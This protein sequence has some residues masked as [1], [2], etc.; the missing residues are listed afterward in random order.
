MKNT[1]FINI[2]NNT[3]ECKLALW[4]ATLL[5]YC[6]KGEVHDVFWL[7]DLNKFDNAQAIRGGIPV[8]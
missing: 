2:S 5:S 4:G 3:A 6:P 8:C 7:G 1:G